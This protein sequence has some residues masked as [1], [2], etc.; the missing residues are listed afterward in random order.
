MPDRKNRRVSKMHEIYENG[1]AMRKNCP[2]CGPG[3]F[4]GKHGNRESCGKCSYTEFNRGD[5]AQK[6]PAEEPTEET[7]E[8]AEEA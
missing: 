4:M 5:S 8:P 6:V 3:V 1:K 7:D 2:K